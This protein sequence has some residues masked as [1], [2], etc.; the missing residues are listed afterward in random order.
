MS[1][2]AFL[3]IQQ[4]NL[5]SK[6]VPT[7]LFY[8]DD[9]APCAQ[10]NSPLMNVT[11]IHGFNGLMVSTDIDMTIAS[12]RATNNAKKVF[13]VWDLEWIRP[14]KNNFD[15]NM[16]AFRDKS[17]TLV[18]RSQEHARAVSEYCNRDDIL[19][20][21]NLNLGALMEALK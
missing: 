1:Q 11:E 2:L 19:V 18:C 3:A 20:I 13:Y 14:G 17:V 4:T 15:Y 5:L 8:S 12:I 7:T 10:T 6:K 9:G 16:L 21:P